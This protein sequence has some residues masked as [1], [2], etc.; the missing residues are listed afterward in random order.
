LTCLT[1]TWDMVWSQPT[2]CEPNLQVDGFDGKTFVISDHIM[3]RSGKF[4]KDN[5]MP[6]CF[7]IHYGLKVVSVIDC[8]E[9]FIE[10]PSNLPKSVTWSQ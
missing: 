2:N 3:V 4:T 9:I 5:A 7:Q 6:F 8:F 1:L 10:K